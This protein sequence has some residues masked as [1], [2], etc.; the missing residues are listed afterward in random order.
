LR[1][2]IGV[3]LLAALAA[4]AQTFEV[5]SIKPSGPKSQRGSDGGPGSKDPLNYKYNAAT[6]KDLIASAYHVQYFQISSKATLDNETFDLVAKLPAGATKD[7][8]RAMMRNLLAERFHLKAR[9]ESKDFPAYELVVAKNGPKISTESRPAAEGFPVL[10]AGQPGMT[11][12]FSMSG[13]YILVRTRAQQQTMDTLASWLQTPDERPVVNKT[14]LDAKYDFTLEYTKDPARG[15]PTT[16]PETPVAP[17]LPTAVQQQL[18]LQLVPKK[19]P[20][21]NVIV[22]SFDKLPTEN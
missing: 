22:E 4:G 7:D 8:F 2:A 20:F 15:A 18:G 16:A 11:S 3:L 12:N 13:G 6:L 5:A 19:L 14:G 1:R 9:V 17:S 21:P 10:P